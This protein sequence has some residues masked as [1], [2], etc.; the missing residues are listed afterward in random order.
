M[1]QLVRAVDQERDEFVGQLRF[2]LEQL[3]RR[4]RRVQVKRRLRVGGGARRQRRREAMRWVGWETCP[5]GA[6]GVL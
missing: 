4:E 2:V 3:G 1:R 6:L 5:T